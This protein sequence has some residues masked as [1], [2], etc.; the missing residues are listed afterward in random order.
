MEIPFSLTQIP[1]PPKQLY[2]EGNLPDPHIYVYIAV[3][4]SRRY[5][6]YG[7]EACEKIIEGLAG[8][9]V[10]IVSGLAIGIDTIAH[11][12]ALRAGLT[13]IAIPGS[14]LD[15]SV[16]Y[17]AQNRKLAD[18]ILSA[19]GALVSEYPPKEKS[20][21]HYFPARNRIMAGLSQGI[22]VV[23]ATAQSGTLITARMALDYNKNVYV[24]PGSIFSPSSYGPNSLMRAGATPITSSED[25]LLELHLK[26]PGELF[27]KELDFS[28]LSPTEQK[29]MEALIE[30][31][32]RDILLQ[33]INVPTN[34]ASAALIML[35]MKGLVK[36]TLGE[37]RRA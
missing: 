13:T 29:I 28:K 30:P 19:G 18:E 7:K 33:E 2:I 22:I 11:K 12:A 35:E 9:P 10:V 23:E 31:M 1:Q 6:M 24:V 32:P 15:R 25:L 4:G 14:G 36:E 37:V 34:E 16:L 17:P 26:S 3:V 8:H 20:W 5:S 27:Q 21:A